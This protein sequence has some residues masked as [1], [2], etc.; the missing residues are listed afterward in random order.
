LNFSSH[1]IYEQNEEDKNGH[2]RTTDYG[3]S[4]GAKHIPPLSKKISTVPFL[5]YGLLTG[6]AHPPPPTSGIDF[7]K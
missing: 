2:G 6:K 5:R 1:G 7:V 4:E 3:K